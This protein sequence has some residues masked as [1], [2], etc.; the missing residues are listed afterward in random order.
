MQKNDVN[1]D[2]DATKHCTMYARREAGG[3]QN[4]QKLQ[5]LKSTLFH[6]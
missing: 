5:E 6:C 4:F 1:R 2:V 3:T